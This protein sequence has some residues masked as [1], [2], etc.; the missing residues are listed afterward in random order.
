MK[1]ILIPIL[2]II[3]TLAVC[4]GMLRHNNPVFIIGIICIIAGYLIFRKLLA[5]SIKK[6]DNIPQ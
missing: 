3:G 2:W 6:K 5:G 1:K 4:Y